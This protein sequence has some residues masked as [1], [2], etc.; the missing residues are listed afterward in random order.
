MNE[1]D[2]TWL[3][4]YALAQLSRFKGRCAQCHTP[5]SR[6]KRFTFHHIWYDDEDKPST[7]FGKDVV[8]YR[9]HILDQVEKKPE[10]FRLFCGGH[11]QLITRLA[12]YGEANLRRACR[13]ARETREH[14]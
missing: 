5:M 6:P 10:K 8:A 7:T 4:K 14:Q 2:K 9:N 11:H 12:Q 13:F 3:R 1:L